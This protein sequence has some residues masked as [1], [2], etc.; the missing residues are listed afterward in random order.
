MIINSKPSTGMPP[1]EKY[2]WKMSVTLTFEPVTLKMSSV[3]LIISKCDKFHYRY[4]ISMH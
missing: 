2:V 4:N 3:D 1:P